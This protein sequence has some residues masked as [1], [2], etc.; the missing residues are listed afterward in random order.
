MVRWKM[1]PVMLLAMAA[2]ALIDS[3]TVEAED[4]TWG[5][6]QVS[7]EVSYDNLTLTLDGNLTVEAGGNLTIADSDITVNGSSPEDLRVL[8]QAGGR[9]NMFNVTLHEADHVY[10]FEVL[11]V[12]EMDTCWVSG[13]VGLSVSGS[14][15]VALRDV[16]V[17]NPRGN[18]ISVGQSAQ[19]DITGG[20]LLGRTTALLTTSTVWVG[21][22]EVEVVCEETRALLMLEDAGSVAASGCT[23]TAD[24][25][26]GAD[27]MAVGVL[28]NGSEAKVILEECAVS[29]PELAEVMGGYFEM[30]N[31]SFTWSPTRAFED[32][33][34]EDGIVILEGVAVNELFFN[35]GRM[36]LIDSPYL[37]G[38]ITGSAQVE[39]VGDVPPL[40]TLD[41][42]VELTHSYW[43][44]FRV[45]NETGVPT[46]GLWVHLQT[47][48][49]GDVVDAFTGPEGWVRRVP[50]RGWTIKDDVRTYEPSHRLEFGGTDYHIS[51]L[52]VYEDTEVILRFT[53]A[54]NDLVL[55]TASVSLTPSAP[56]SNRTFEVRVDG[57]VLVPDTWDDGEAS[58]ELH[59]D[60]TFYQRRTLLL[61]A[62]ED[63]VFEVTGLEQ[64]THILQVRVDPL[65]EVPEIND[66]GNNVISLA[67]DIAPSSGDPGDLMDLYIEIRRLRDTEGNEGET[68]LPG[69]IFVDFTVRASNALVWP[70]NV[71]VAI[72]VDDMVQE[73]AMVDLDEREGTE[74]L[75][76]GRMTL[77]LV[78]GTYD[79]R[80]SVDPD[81]LIEEE[82]ELNN[83]DL[84]RV[85]LDPDING[86][87]DLDPACCSSILFAA[88]IMA[89]SLLSAYT[90]RR[91]QAGAQ[92]RTKETI[93]YPQTVMTGREGSRPVQDYARPQ[94]AYGGRQGGLSD[95]W[96][97]ERIDREM[98]SLY[99]V[100]GRAPR[101]TDG[102]VMS[103]PKPAPPSR[104]RFALT[105]LNCPRCSGNDILGFSDGSAKCQA[106]GKI[107]Y[108]ERRSR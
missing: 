56:R 81:D 58:I 91:R 100:D 92:A 21:L 65:D 6:T 16:D 53:E 5:D 79:I 2:V 26:L 18:A 4:A 48:S 105:G 84:A 68:L 104:D 94:P 55:T 77:N 57:E 97:A 98:G 28:V 59:I 86:G 32:L 78:R 52:Q 46:E 7:S 22:S 13:H 24:G 107:F 42:T 15:V 23:L 87:F 71:P 38:T 72:L 93:Q 63:V 62:R 41:S 70:R 85:T 66:G 50:V 49:G 80:L 75:H 19:V 10:R 29:T 88:I 27:E 101:G 36:A 20:R 9:L 34:C 103:R 83:V 76:R 74:W 89:V 82:F 106:C 25:L 108:P 1:L 12:L 35:G 69:V 64:G 60:G 67:I 17:V 11:G 96:T 33:W 95:Q 43:V 45:L 31:G 61:D 99:G 39:S 8:V 102:I 44:D 90:Q 40:S 3:A 73:V 47:S 37:V 30:V 14:A 51:N 54:R